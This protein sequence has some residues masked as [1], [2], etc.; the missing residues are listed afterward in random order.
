L[1]MLQVQRRLRA[2]LRQWRYPKEF[3]IAPALWTDA[4]LEALSEL[5]ERALSA[6]RPPANQ[7]QTQAPERLGLL[8]DIGTGLWRL[9]QK[10][11]EPGGEKPLPEMRRAYRHLQSVWDRL[12]DAGFEIRYYTGMRYDAG[13]NLNVVTYQQRATAECERIIETVKPSIYYNSEIVQLG[14]VIVETAEDHRISPG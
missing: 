4:A 8:A 12:A 10:M 11:V 13:L 5:S 2:T 9:R 7:P 3:R 14:D 6:A 1:S